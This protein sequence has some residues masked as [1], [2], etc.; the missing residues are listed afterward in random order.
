MSRFYEHRAFGIARGDSGGLAYSPPAVAAGSSADQKNGRQ[1]VMETLARG[2]S[3]RLREAAAR[4]P[5]HRRRR[6]QPAG[7]ARTIRRARI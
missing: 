2:A 5:I 6:E 3:Q 4:A 7:L 1:R